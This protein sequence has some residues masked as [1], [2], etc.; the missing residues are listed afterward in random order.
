MTRR[1]LDRA[2]TP[3]RFGSRPDWAERILLVGLSALVVAVLISATRDLPRVDLTVHN[4][5]SCT[6]HL[7]IAGA[8]PGGALDLGDISPSGTRAS[9]VIDQGETWRFRT[10]YGGRTIGEMSLPRATL[11]ESGWQVRLPSELTAR[12]GTAGCGA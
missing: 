6:V 5:S 1:T 9:R 8:P 10:R 2:P 12:S 11:V 3:K 4:P 7:E